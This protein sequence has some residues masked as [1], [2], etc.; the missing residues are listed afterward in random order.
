[1]FPADCVDNQ[2]RR[3][4]CVDFSLLPEKKQEREQRRKRNNS[5]FMFSRINV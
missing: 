4:G 5:F 2:M 3:V 1:M